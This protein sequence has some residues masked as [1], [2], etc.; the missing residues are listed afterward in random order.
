MR[1]H[2]AV[3]EEKEKETKLALV[4]TRSKSA[5]ER[6]ELKQSE[7]QKPNEIGN[8]NELKSRVLNAETSWNQPMI[9]TIKRDG[10]SHIIRVHKDKT[11]LFEIP[12]HNSAN[13]ESTL[14]STLKRLDERAHG[15]GIDEL[16]ITPDDQLIGLKGQVVS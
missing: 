4:I 1:E 5:K 14:E 7:R 12:V 8:D 11:I 9:K 2:T 13:N 6:Q 15:M 10:L 3:E 16:Q